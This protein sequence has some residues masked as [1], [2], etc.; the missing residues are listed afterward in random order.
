MKKATK[1]G[2]AS[3][4]ATTF[5]AGCQPQCSDVATF[6]GSCNNP[7]NPEMGVAGSY[8]SAGA[9]GYEFAND[10][11]SP[12][13]TV[14]ERFISNELMANKSGVYEQ[15][16]TGLA[17]TTLWFGQFVTHDISRIDTN[18]DHPFYTITTPAI[19]GPG[20][21]GEQVAAARASGSKEDENRL[22]QDMINLVK[23]FGAPGIKIPNPINDE[24]AIM[25]KSRFNPN[26]PYT[27][28]I[29]SETILLPD[30]IFD[31]V[32]GDKKVKNFANAYL[33]LSNIYGDN[34][35]INASL[36][37]GQGG[38]L[39]T[40]DKEVTTHYRP[41]D[42]VT[43]V[44]HDTLPTADMVAH[45]RSVDPIRPFNPEDE[46][47]SG[48]LRASENFNL[49][50]M[51]IAFHRYHNHIA[52][53]KMAALAANNDP[54]WWTRS[55]ADK[56]EVIFQMTRRYVTAIY[57]NIIFED[58]LPALLGSQFDELI[59]DYKGYDSSIDVSTSGTMVNTAFRY[60]HSSIPQDIT[61]VDENG[62]NV[63]PEEHQHEIFSLQFGQV[64]VPGLGQTGP[65]K[66]FTITDHVNLS[67]AGFDNI[68][69][70]MTNNPTDKIDLIY[71]DAIR[72]VIAS[73]SVVAAGVDVAAID[74]KRARDFGVPNFDALR[75]VYGG[76]SVYEI[77]DCSFSIDAVIDDVACFL[78]VTS[79][80]E[81]ANALRNVYGK[82][83]KMD[84]IIGLLAEDQVAGSP[85][86]RTS[87]AIIAD[88]FNKKRHGD[89]FWY[90]N[91][92]IMG[93]SWMAEIENIGFEDV[94]AQTACGNGQPDCAMTTADLDPNGDGVFLVDPNGT[95]ETF[96]VGACEYVDVTPFGDLPQCDEPVNRQACATRTN[97]VFV[98]N[99]QA[100]GP[101]K[102]PEVNSQG[103][104]KLGTCVFG[105]AH[106]RASIYEG[107][108]TAEIQQWA[109]EAFASGL[110][111]DGTAEYL[112]VI[113]AAGGR[114][115]NEFQAMDS[116][117]PGVTPPPPTETGDGFC[118]FEESAPTG[119]S[120]QVCSSQATEAA[121][122]EQ[123]GYYTEQAC[124][125]EGVVGTCTLENG[126]VKSYYT[127]DASSLEI[128]CGFSNGTW[129]TVNG[130]DTGGGDTSE[131]SGAC[132]YLQSSPGGSFNVCQEPTLAS[133]CAANNGSLDLANAC[134][135]SVIVGTCTLADGAA[136][137][138]YDGDAA[139]LATGC[140]FQNG[141]WS[142][143]ST[144]EEPQPEPPV[145]DTGACEYL[146]VPPFGQSYNVC[147]S[148]QTAEACYGSGEQSIVF[149]AGEQCPTVH[150][151]LGNS[152]GF[153]ALDSGNLYYYE[154]DG[155]DPSTGCGF[156]GGTWV[157]L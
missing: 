104:A 96:E 112:E 36:R 150:E 46:F 76:G 87:A 108:A 15:S 84:G 23:Q 35:E 88:E 124:N 64:T 37:T 59:G 69:R 7:D 41:L 58:Y 42:P 138:Y 56:D 91:P 144:D 1:L 75:T 65:A 72:N 44:I 83:N 31:I 30:V 48:D 136:I 28:I 85:L 129:E 154:A 38:T 128:G 18:L 109:C 152:I 133:T 16:K 103:A 77:E 94:L 99:S 151:T 14:N 134:D 122:T 60:A 32:E 39:V 25:S 155:G 74:V 130:G 55:E 73:Q 146:Q 4:V 141:T 90:Q 92:G 10:G 43:N 82:V 135:T 79:D 2:L 157:S 62:H 45:E 153:C 106:M 126:S 145:S 98:G 53:T 26:L 17:Q 70:S 93:D 113:Q 132:T 24:L 127:G 114:I 52:S 110:W 49:T 66:P 29:P 148:D 105:F 68:I 139:S 80:L 140:G 51:H 156:Q 86:S 125:A 40:I 131:P 115:D 78:H 63:I 20:G 102:C 89:R 147:K 120:F 50:A 3:A 27:G 11:V 9:E 95:Y 137:H 107:P 123:S 142:A 33:D 100:Y 5:L 13:I 47:Q 57:Q 21:L 97:G 67:G 117:P 111:I 149:N 19:F 22:I 121:C 143:P 8:F 71:P 118:N 6:D 119:D 101:T 54:F 61:I 81:T 116:L 34:E 12:A